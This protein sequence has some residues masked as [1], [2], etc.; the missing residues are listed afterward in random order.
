MRPK[1]PRWALGS[2]RRIDDLLRRAS[3]PRLSEAEP[4]FSGKTGL[5]LLAEAY[6]D[7]YPQ[8]TSIFADS[9]P[10]SHS[11]RVHLRNLRIAAA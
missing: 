5:E 8:T 3:L 9:I 10:A 1:S 11:I 7:F 4:L 2:R 6:G